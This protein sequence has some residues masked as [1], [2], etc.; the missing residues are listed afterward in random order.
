[1]TQ[2]KHVTL[3]AAMA[4]IFIGCTPDPDPP[5]PTPDPISD[6]FD[7]AMTT[8]PYD[9]I[10]G[11]TMIDDLYDYSLIE[12]PIGFSFDF[13]GEPFDHLYFN[14]LAPSPTFSFEQ[15]PDV[16]D[17]RYQELIL[18]GQL[19]VEPLE[20]LG[21]GGPDTISQVIYQTSG[22][23]GNQVFTMEYRDWG[24]PSN[25][26]GQP[27]HYVFDMTLKLYE[28]GNRIEIHYGGNSVATPLQ[29][30]PFKW[31]Q[32]GLYGDDPNQGFYLYGDPANPD[33]SATILFSK[34]METWPDSGTVY[35][36]LQ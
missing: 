28:N 13:C 12:V 18:F 26:L 23:V 27:S 34:E 15:L 33:S 19:L 17:L 25:Q 36:F 22:P 10:V 11:G 4:L 2:F 20:L 21:S 1:M 29:G 8:Q 14:E 31:L 3:W 9:T 24:F 7:F 16:L 5:V 32:V 35:Q 30:D 6:C